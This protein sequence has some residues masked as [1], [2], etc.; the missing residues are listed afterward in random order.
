MVAT[1]SALL[2]M[3]VGIAAVVYAVW[4]T[5]RRSRVLALLDEPAAGN[6][7]AATAAA[8]AWSVAAGELKGQ[9]TE[10]LDPEEFPK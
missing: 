10:A 6:G 5:L 4:P 1:V 9:E 8:R 7:E 3:F 2:A